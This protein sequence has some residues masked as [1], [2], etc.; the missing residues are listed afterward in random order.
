M[1]PVETVRS[2]IAIELPEDVKETL[3][4]MLEELR[5]LRFVK[6]A[7]PQGVHLT[8]KFLGN[9]PTPKLALVETAMRQVA[10]GATPFDLEASELGAFPDLR[11]PRVAWVGVKGEVEKLLDLQKNLGQALAPLGFAPEARGFSPH[12]TL[13]RVREQVSPP[14]RQRLG[15]ALARLEMGKASHIP[16]KALSLIKSQLTPRGPI[17]SLLASAPLGETVLP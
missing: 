12:L 5:P 7:G 2:F 11:R 1:E 6:W 10:A 4:Q 3:R 16:V 17:Y 13:G 15:D 8:L 9:V 14:D